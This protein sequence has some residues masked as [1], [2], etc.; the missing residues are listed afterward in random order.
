MKTTRSFHR[1]DIIADQYFEGSLK[2]GVRESRGSEQFLFSLD[3][4]TQLPS[5]FNKNF[6]SN[7]TNKTNL[8]T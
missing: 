7:G 5:E 3:D 1:C 8:N 4:H 6:L 2:E